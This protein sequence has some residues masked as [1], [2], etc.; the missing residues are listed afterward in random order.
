MEQPNEQPTKFIQNSKNIWVI[1]V[2][3]V[4]TALVVGGVVYAWQRSNLKNTEQSLQEQISALQSQISQLQQVQ[5]GQNQQANQQ[6][7]E[8][9]NQPQQP[10]PTPTQ[11]SYEFTF[12]NKNNFPITQKEFSVLQH[13][14]AKDLESKS[15]ECGTNKNR[16]YFSNLL[17]KF[18]SSDKGYAYEI[19]YTG[20]TQDSGIWKI[21]VVPNKMGYKNLNE[22]KNDFDLCYAGGDEYPNLISE[23]Y[24]LFVSSCGTGFDD[25]S[26]LP[27]GCDVIRELIEP[28]IILK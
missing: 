20:Q 6:V 28:T 16:T 26:G 14:S 22:F 18:S 9:D 13:F 11:Q 23:N 5:S 12:T 27:H 19:S 10:T 4:V 3:I 1:V 17:S 25:G 2:S 15:Q 21:T 24:L 8:Q 7:V